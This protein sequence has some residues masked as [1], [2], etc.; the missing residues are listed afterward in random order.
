MYPHPNHIP[1]PPHSAGLDYK[2]TR[3][4]SS[5]VVHTHERRIG[6][7]PRIDPTQV[8]SPIDAIENDRIAW[9]T[10]A[11]PTLPG[12]HAP[13]CTSDFVAVDQGSLSSNVLSEGRAICVLDR[14]CITQ[15]RPCVHLEYAMQSQ[16]GIRVPDTPFR[17]IPTLRRPRST[18]RARSTNRNRPDRAA[19]V[20][21]VQGIRESVVSLGGGR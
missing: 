6:L 11:F 20:Q 5:T 9:Q 21:E 15:V 10:K 18:R 13:L 1:Q 14:Q 3:G 2:G 17:R 7:R 16:V 8:P 4:F 12:T 19:A